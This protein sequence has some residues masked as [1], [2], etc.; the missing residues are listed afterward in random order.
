MKTI[1][2]DSECRCHTT[3]PEGNF[4][5]IVLSDNA[6]VFFTD[7]CTAFIEGYRLKPEGETWVR[8]DG[9]VF[10]GGEMITPWKPYDELD[11][12]Q[13]EYEWQKLAE[14]ESARA[15]IEKALGVSV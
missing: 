8:E 12:A 7:K 5:E 14:Y 11:A 13:R 9:E 10:S 6:R 4:R 15:E 3:N 2:I 1:Y